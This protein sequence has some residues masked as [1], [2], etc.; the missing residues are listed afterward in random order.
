MQTRASY[1][2]SIFNLH[3]NSASN[4]SL[5]S[6]PM[7]LQLRETTMLF[8]FQC[9]R[10]TDDVTS[11]LYFILNDFFQQNCNLAQYIKHLRFL[12]SQYA[13][14]TKQICR[15]MFVFFAQSTCHTHFAQFIFL[16][17]NNNFDAIFI[18]LCANSLLVGYCCKA[19]AMHSHFM[20]RQRQRQ[21]PHRSFQYLHSTYSTVHSLCA[22]LLSLKTIL[23]SH[24][25]NLSLYLLSRLLLLLLSFEYSLS[26]S[27]VSTFCV[28]HFQSALLM[29]NAKLHCEQN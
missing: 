10:R 9:I 1:I 26:F 25:T 5:R 23:Q 4:V 24:F 6:H 16:K 2:Y 29:G 11:H 15:G 27:F 20:Q 22:A 21:W 19:N 12:N 14:W 8:H 18:S 13:D 7:C 17:Y 28:N 3:F